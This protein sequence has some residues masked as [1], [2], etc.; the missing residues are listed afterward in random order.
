M[1]VL[2]GVARR[3]KKGL[4]NAITEGRNQE[5]FQGLFLIELVDLE[6]WNFRPER[7]LKIKSIA[8]ILWPGQLNCPKSQS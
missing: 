1:I 5:L 7:T 4:Q 3:L 6:S 8:L 2:G